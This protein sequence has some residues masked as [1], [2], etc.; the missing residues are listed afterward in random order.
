VRWEGKRNAHRRGGSRSGGRAQVVEEQ[1]KEF[2][3]T[4][5]EI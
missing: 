1:Q 2:F 4:V 5:L 3:D